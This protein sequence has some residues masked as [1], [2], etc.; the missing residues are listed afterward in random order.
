[1]RQTAI[2]LAALLALGCEDPAGPSSGRLP[3]AGSTG[4][5][6]L[7]AVSC[8]T[9]ADA[10]VNPGRYVGQLGRYGW[11]VYSRASAEYAERCTGFETASK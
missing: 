10:V 1:M 3:S 6:G 9:L 4:P 7:D 8:A 11:D 2:M 5:T